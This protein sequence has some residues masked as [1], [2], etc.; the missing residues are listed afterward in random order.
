MGVY[1][2]CINVHKPI[3]GKYCIAAIKLGSVDGRTFEL[4]HKDELENFDQ[5]WNEIL[6]VHYYIIYYNNNSNNNYFYLSTKFV[7]R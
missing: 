3:Q 6:G 4:N 2:E 5:A 7:N 1:E